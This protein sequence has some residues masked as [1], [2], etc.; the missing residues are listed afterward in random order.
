M[1]QPSGCGPRQ[2]TNRETRKE[3]EATSWP[4]VE[5]AGLC[6]EV[7]TQAV[8]CWGLRTGV[9]PQ[10]VRKWKSLGRPKSGFRMLEVCLI[11]T[12]SS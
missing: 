1:K 2:K 4:G 6:A 8:R 10:E 3:K 7:R 11:A 12:L 9:W 5:I